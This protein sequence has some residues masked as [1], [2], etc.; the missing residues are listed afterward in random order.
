MKSQ[1]CNWRSIILR[2]DEQFVLKLRVRF[3][4]SVPKGGFSW[5][6]QGLGG[7]S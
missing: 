6:L 2:C 3:E 4:L 5:A 1:A 7:L